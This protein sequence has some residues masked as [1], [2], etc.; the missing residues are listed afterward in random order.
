MRD[1]L[2]RSEAHFLA[3]PSHQLDTGAASPLR[4]R[5]TKRQNRTQ[6]RDTT[7]H[8]IRYRPVQSKLSNLAEVWGWKEFSGVGGSAEVFSPTWPSPGD[9]TSGLVEGVVNAAL[10]LSRGGF[11]PGSLEVTDCTADKRNGNQVELC[12]RCTE[13]RDTYKPDQPVQ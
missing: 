4:C 8:I 3:L 5:Y 10:S 9:S 1:T 11:Q 12:I 6:F 13:F 2:L 7:H